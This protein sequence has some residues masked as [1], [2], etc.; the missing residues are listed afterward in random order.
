MKCNTLAWETAAPGGAEH[1]QRIPSSV[2][3]GARSR[4]GAEK[5]GMLRAGHGPS[6]GPILSHA[7]AGIA[8]QRPTHPCRLLPAAQSPSPSGGALASRGAAAPP[9]RSL[10]DGV[11]SFVD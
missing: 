4:G 10:N 3:R 6:P 8:A 1:G 7:L 11:K 2:G 5:P 9:A